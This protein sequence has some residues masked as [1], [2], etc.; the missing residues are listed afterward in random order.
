MLY[1][2]IPILDSKVFL[3]SLKNVVANCYHLCL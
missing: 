3:E 1:L 2:T